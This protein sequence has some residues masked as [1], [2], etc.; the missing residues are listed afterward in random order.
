MDVDG[1]K[2]CS[3]IFIFSH[4]NRLKIPSDPSDKQVFLERLNHQAARCD[5]VRVVRACQVSMVADELWVVTPGRTRLETFECD[6]LASY[7]FV[8]MGDYG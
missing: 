5:V 4:R 6:T 7:G 1:L 3:T 2:M 8:S